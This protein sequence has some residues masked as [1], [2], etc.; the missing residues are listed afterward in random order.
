MGRVCVKD[1]VASGV[2]DVVVADLDLG[3]AE[4]LVGSSAP[5]ATPVAVDAT[6]H[7]ALV[8]VLEGAD[9]VANC[10]NYAINTQ[11][12][13]AAAAANVDYLDLGGLY[14]GTRR[15]LELHAEMEAAGI[16]CLL[17]MGSTP[18]TMNVMAAHGAAMLDEV[19]EIHLRCG[20]YDPEPPSAPLPAPYAIDT[21]LDEF[22]LPGMVLEN[23]LLQEVAPASHDE[24]FDFPEP[25]GEQT[26]VLTLHSELAT[27]PET[28]AEKGLRTCTFKVAF[29]EDFIARY[30]LVAA[31]GLASTEPVPTGD[32]AQVVPRALLKT[33]ALGHPQEFSGKDIES[34]V[35]LL[36]G[37][38][39][40]RSV[41][42][43]VEEISPPNDAYGVGGADANTGIPPSVVAQMIARGTIKGVGALAPE[44]V[45]PPEEYFA[46]LKRRG[47]EISVHESDLDESAPG[48]L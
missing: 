5:G 35:V 30:R 24:R 6:D 27:M 14:R 33:L 9:V 8:G 31:L 29:G 3:R 12:M 46:E 45:V 38:R 36:R 20:G 1:L 42:I 13:N 11:V 4:Q 21:I 18:G 40:G 41:E 47:I 28:F 23:G 19:H 10:A 22:T 44:Q 48:Y 34:L 37:V 16:L 25:V 26:A 2:E 43:R 7:G 39:D 17:G 15:Q 32:G